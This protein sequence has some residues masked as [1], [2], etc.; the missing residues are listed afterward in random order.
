MPMIMCMYFRNTWKPIPP[1]QWSGSIKNQTTTETVKFQSIL[2]SR[3]YVD[4]Y[5]TNICGHIISRGK[6]LKMLGVTRG[7]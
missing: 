1:K 2:L 3:R 7:W 5:D 6:S 4:D